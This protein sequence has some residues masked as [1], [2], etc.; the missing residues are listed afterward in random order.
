MASPYIYKNTGGSLGA[1][2]TT[3]RP[4]YSSGQRWYVSSGIGSDAYNGRERHKP[5]ATLA[6]AHTAAAA[7][8]S[9]VCL[10][11][12]VEALAV[13]QT[14]NKARIKLYGEGEGSSLPRFTANGAIAMFDITAAGVQIESIYFPASTAAPTA[15]VRTAS[16]FTR[17]TNCIFEC[18][19]SDTAAALRLIT[20]CGQF[21]GY[22]CQFTSTAT[23]VT[24]QPNCGFEVV[25]AVTGVEL[26]TF[27]F[28]GGTKGWSD[29]ALKGTAAITDFYFLDIDLLNDSDIFFAT[30]TTGDLHIRNE[31]GSARVQWD[32]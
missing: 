6:A 32:A 19:P 14:F 29:Y 26:D 1:R 28:D 31:S 20:G 12:H 25:N 13:A 23:V 15:R 27:I 2:L 30:G 16:T 10:A 3:R 5:L 9:I 18:G 24:S 22:G 11:G 4:V 8:D 17:V 21:R 7:G